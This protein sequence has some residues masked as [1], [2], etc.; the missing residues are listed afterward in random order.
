MTTK[1]ILSLTLLVL[2]IGSLV[3][4]S[5][6]ADGD[7]SNKPIIV[8]DDKSKK[9]DKG[10]K[11]VLELYQKYYDLQRQRDIAGERHDARRTTAW[12]ETRS[13]KQ[14]LAS[15]SSDIEVHRQLLR[16]QIEW[17]QADIDWLATIH[18]IDEKMDT[19]R[20]ELKNRGEPPPP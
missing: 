19:I 8:D 1:K 17:K 16:A 3:I 4:S 13:A 18:P 11:Q 2:V 9:P 14:Q 5:V 6:M 12:K 10:N 7:K 20:T 15:D